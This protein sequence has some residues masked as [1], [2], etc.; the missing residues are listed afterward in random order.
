MSLSELQSRVDALEARLRAQ[1]A[2]IPGAADPPEHWDAESGFTAADM[3]PAP[4]DI[5]ALIDATAATAPEPTIPAELA[6]LL[7]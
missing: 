2:G 3:A 1:L 5:E 7:G 4:P 6:D